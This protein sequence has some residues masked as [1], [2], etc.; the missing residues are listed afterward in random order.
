LDIKGIKGIK[1]KKSIKD[2]PKY[3]IKVILPINQEAADMYIDDVMQEVEEV[4]APDFDFEVVGLDQKATSFI[5]SRKSEEW[6]APFI[7]EVAIQA[8]KDG[9]DGIFISC[10]GEPGV[11]ALREQLKIPIVGGFFPSVSQAQLVCYK[12]A[13]IS[14]VESVLPMISYIGN[15]K[16]VDSRIVSYRQIGVPVADLTDINLVIKKT[17]EQATIAIETDG[18]EAIV[19]GCTGML[20]VAEPVQSALSAHY[21][22]LGGEH[23]NVPVI[24]PTAAAITMLQ[25][26]IRSKTYH[27]NLT[28][29]P[30]TEQYPAPSTKE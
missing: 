24:A 29:Y 17:V 5:Q 16:E 27:S 23:C 6:N 28:Y 11:E 8:E 2:D 25:S 26:L 22:S 13:I 12:Y 19:L 7:S 21:S 14:V 3:K 9:F 1:V 18:A 30:P 15:A 10:F 20:G 4:L